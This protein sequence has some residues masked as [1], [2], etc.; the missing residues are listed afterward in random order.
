MKE[1]EQELS[2]LNQ[3]ISEQNPQKLVNEL[4]DKNKHLK[5]I[6]S[7]ITKYVQAFSDAE[8]S[9]IRKLRAEL[10]KKQNSASIISKRLFEDSNLEGVG[11]EAWKNLWEYARAYSNEVAYKDENF[12]FTEDDAL[13]VLCQQS[14]NDDAKARLLSFED[15]VKGEA[16]NAVIKARKA[17]NDK[18]ES[19]PEVSSE[20]GFTTLISASGLE[21]DQLKDDLL[22]FHK[23]IQ[24]RRKVFLQEPPFPESMTPLID[25]DKCL[26]E[27]KRRIQKNDVLIQQCTQDTETE[28]RKELVARANSLKAQEWVCEHK[29]SIIDEINKLKQIALLQ[30]AKKLAGTS[31]LSKKKGEL[32]EELI[33]QAYV[34]RFKQEKQKLGADRVNVE[35][36]KAGTKKGKTHHKI[37]LVD[38][39][40]SPKKIL[41][42]GENRIFALAAFLA[43][44]TGRN[45]SA[46]IVFDDPI[47]S[48]DQ[49]FE[50][51]F[52]TR[53]VELSFDRQI[54]IFTHRISMFVFLQ[55]AAKLRE[56]K[57]SFNHL[58]D[59]IWGIGEPGDLPLHIK[60]PTSALDT[61]SSEVE[62]AIK[63]QE[64]EGKES[65]ALHV[66]SICTSF[67]KILERIVEKHL[68]NDI[69][70]RYRT[71]IQTKRK[72]DA[73]SQINKEDCRYIGNFITKYSIFLHAQSEEVD[74]TL[75]ELTEIQQDITE[76]LSWLKEFTKKINP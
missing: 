23:I 34:D 63:V 10:E 61:L 39:K 70:Q 36:V 49:D 44:I 21:S 42:E 75:P 7:N 71:E 74:A 3:R 72:L 65:C 24:E 59:D 22:N 6:V 33:T 29:Q 56:V 55:D 38:A 12:P 2:E 50:R 13:C 54:I 25:I 73:L 4:A 76:L 28:K 35:L 62:K 8:Y 43:D 47:S 51:K 1:E 46:P 30:K 60:N 57:I 31:A 58:R 48:L 16:E 41:S 20:K 5:D 37:A 68:L 9:E 18:L 15:Y 40:D 17:L 67:R 53:L 69:V 52:A 64:H 66:Q 32:S 26:Q 14:L 27:V 19:L 11:D 45:N